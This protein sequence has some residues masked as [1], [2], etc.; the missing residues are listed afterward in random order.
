[1]MKLERFSPD[2]PR[3]WLN[4]A[5]SSLI[6]A[7]SCK[8]LA[9]VYFEDVCFDAQQAAEKA[10]KAVL[11][12]RRA[13]FPWT[14]DLGVLLDLLRQAGVAIPQD[15]AECVTLTRYATAG[16]YPRSVEPVNDDECE[17]AIRQAETVV[18]WA[19]AAVQATRTQSTPHAE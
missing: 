16:R 10:I 8:E 19:G 9:G 13:E 5:R 6:R 11:L 2:D 12:S 15:V 4:R 17:T 1:M 14:H 3:E 18:R 7:S